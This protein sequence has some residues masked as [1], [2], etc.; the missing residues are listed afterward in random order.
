MQGR[1]RMTDLDA[2][3]G[4]SE[5]RID[6][7]DPARSNALLAAL[8][9]ARRVERGDLLPALHHWVHFWPVL[10]PAET[11]PDGH[12]RKGGFLPPVPLPRR[13]WAGGQLA[14]Q[15]PLRLGEEVRRR[16]TVSAIEEKTGRS[17]RLVFVTV[18]HEL[19]GPSGLAIE[20]RQDLVYREAGGAAAEGP[21]AEGIGPETRRVETDPVLLFRYSA[22]TMN[23]HRIHY[24]LPYA[25]Q[26]ESY[27]ALVVQGPLQ[28]TILAA[29]AERL[30]GA[31]PTT[32][33]FRGVSAA[34]CGAPLAIHASSE[35]PGARLWSV[36][37][38]RVR[39]TARAAARAAD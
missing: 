22:L 35:A 4:R 13:M 23:S 24:D 38:G 18:R 6:T 30:L 7:L 37:D 33:E 12:P 2:W 5:E 25:R 31:P 16:S 19:H 27:P 32:F 1:P 39:M 34:L 8:G 20:E 26:E 10:S 21:L 15:A 3:I 14:F 36:Q 11:G 17:G 9:D 29:E 28:A